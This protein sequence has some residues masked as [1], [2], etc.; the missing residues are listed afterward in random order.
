MIRQF[1]AFNQSV[2][3]DGVDLEVLPQRLDALVVPA[4]DAQRACTHDG[5]QERIRLDIHFMHRVSGHVKPGMAQLRSELGRQILIKRPA[6]D[7]GKE[8][9]STANGQD[10]HPAC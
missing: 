1:N 4:V 10:R 3:S 2:R 8:L 7:A 6:Q 5:G 9:H